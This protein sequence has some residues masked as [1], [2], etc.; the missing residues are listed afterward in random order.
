MSVLRLLPAAA[1]VIRTSMMKDLGLE[2]GQAAANPVLFYVM[3]L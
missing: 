1:V 2:I 3:Y